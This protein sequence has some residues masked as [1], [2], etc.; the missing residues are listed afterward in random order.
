[1][2]QVL[3]CM[4]AIRIHAP[5][6]APPSE[7]V[8]LDDVVHSVYLGFGSMHP[9]CRAPQPTAPNNATAVSS[10]TSSNF[11]HIVRRY[12]SVINGAVHHQVCI[13]TNGSATK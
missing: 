13:H 12:V 11:R 4:G 7:A 6:R 5:G 9:T 2:R 1:M 8:V 10:S 3:E